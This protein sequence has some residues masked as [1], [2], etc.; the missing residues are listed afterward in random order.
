M[1]KIF[2]LSILA[3]AGALSAF[4]GTPDK[5][6]FSVTVPAEGVGSKLSLTV[7]SKVADQSYVIDWGNGVKG[8]ATVASNKSAWWDGDVTG[9]TIKVYGE[10]PDDITGVYVNPYSG[11]AKAKTA[12]AFVAEP[13]A[14]LNK[15][16]VKDNQ[17][18]VLNLTNLPN[19]TELDASNNLLTNIVFAA[20]NKIQK[21][22]LSNSQSGNNLIDADFSA[23]TN[24]KTLNLENNK[25]VTGNVNFSKLTSVET[26]TLPNCGISS[27]VLPQSANL[28]VL[29]LHYNNLA[30]IDLSGATGLTDLNVQDNQFSIVSIASESLKSLNLSNNTTLKSIDFSKLPALDRLE[31]ANCG[32]TSF[33]FSKA[34][35]LTYIDVNDNALTAVDLSANNALT[36]FLCND[37]AIKSLILPTEPKLNYLSA[38]N[39]TEKGANAIAN[40][41]FSKCVAMKTLFLDNNLCEPFEMDITALTSLASFTASNCNISAIKLPNSANFTTI[42]LEKNQLTSLDVPN[43]KSGAGWYSVFLYANDNKLTSLT[44]PAGKMLTRLYAQNNCLTFKELGALKGSVKTASSF[45][46]A[47]QASLGE[48]QNGS[49]DLSR[50]VGETVNG[51]PTVITWKSGEA[52]IPEA[53]DGVENVNGVYTLKADYANATCHITNADLPNLTLTTVP[54]NV[55]TKLFSFIPGVDSEGCA[56]EFSITTTDSQKIRVDWGNGK[57]TAPIA[58]APYLPLYSE[59]TVEGTI[60]G[61][62]VTVYG[63]APANVDRLSLG[64]IANK[65]VEAS[66]A[67]ILDITPLTGLEVLDISTNNVKALDLRNNP[68][69]SSL[70]AP[71]NSIAS[72]KFPANSMLYSIDFSNGATLGDNAALN[73]D[74]ASLAELKTLKLNYNNKAGVPNVV[75]MA[76]FPAKLANLY[77]LNNEITAI[78]G[79]IPA[80]L[81]YVSFNGNKLTTLDASNMVATATLFATGNNLTEIKV[82]A[83]LKTMNISGNKFTFSTLPA[84]GIATGYIY[85]NQQPMVITADNGV[86][87]LTAEANVGNQATVFA[88]TANGAAFS[89]FTAENGKFVFNKDAAQAVCTMT[90]TA[91]PKLTLT[92]VAIDITANE[93][94]VAD[95]AGDASEAEY[96][97]LQGQKVANPTKGQILIKRQSGKTAKVI[98]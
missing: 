6:L 92:T 82:P 29:K 4:A 25:S 41:D 79:A 84:V 3:V 78:E 46:Y 73:A 2:T 52:I 39:T 69:L 5:L 33:D 45:Y 50:F 21:L 37:N 14:S 91:F 51:Q 24:L 42:N 54:V 26:L 58:T 59:T 71:N 76:S 43:F 7:E 98:F 48:L 96:F 36:N 55:L 70:T 81:T 63:D 56:K 77:L 19:M 8:D 12:I 47:P 94:G 97:N 62:I 64:Y 66:K 60:E 90:N 53:A 18:S 83:K 16:D 32:L 49:I 68:K 67:E 35:A 11:T 31:V 85:D 75:S 72:I 44:L 9:T 86:V 17:L 15:L 20:E 88:W 13:M 40:A 57:L 28:K 27:I 74:Y 30:S 22:T 23:C 38:Q 95:L 93:T 10:N 34:T 80:N 65:Q 1:K 87:D 89:D 61:P